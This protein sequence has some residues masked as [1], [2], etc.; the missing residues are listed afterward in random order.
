MDLRVIYECDLKRCRVKILN[1]GGIIIDRPFQESLYMAPYA[2]KIEL[3]SILRQV[4]DEDREE[5]RKTW[6]QI[7]IKISS[8]IGRN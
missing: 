7:Q 5:V 3:Q 6:H 4:P 1:I 2:P 8:L